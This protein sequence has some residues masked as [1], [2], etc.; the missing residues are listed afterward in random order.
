[1]LFFVSVRMSA[2]VWWGRWI[3]QS[4]RGWLSASDSFILA[5]R[6]NEGGLDT[7]KPSGQPARV[8]S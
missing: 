4:G 6:S 5:R 2:G 7:R 3:G 1:M 8:A